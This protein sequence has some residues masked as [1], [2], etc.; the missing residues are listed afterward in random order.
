MDSYHRQIQRR[1]PRSG[2][3]CQFCSQFGPDFGKRSPI[4]RRVDAD[5]SATSHLTEN[6]HVRHRIFEIA[7]K[8]AL[9]SNGGPS[10]TKTA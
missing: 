9:A 3:D 2:R 5:D 8:R 6:G 1:D 7:R 10:L 4:D